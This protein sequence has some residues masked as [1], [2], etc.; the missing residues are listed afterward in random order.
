MKFIPLMTRKAIEKA[1]LLYLF[2]HIIFFLI[3]TVKV[4]QMMGFFGGM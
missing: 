4:G 1:I 3:Y 2:A